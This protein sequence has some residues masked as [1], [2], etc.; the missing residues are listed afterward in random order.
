M[1]ST[2]F[3]GS[4]LFI[5]HRKFFLE[6]EFH[7]LHE[8]EPMRS[9]TLDGYCSC[10]GSDDCGKELEYLGHVVPVYFDHNEHEFYELNE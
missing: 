8:S 5:S 4:S 6:H 9:T 7:K 10:N 2:S 3:M 1:Y